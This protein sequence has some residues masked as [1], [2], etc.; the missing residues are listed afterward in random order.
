[1]AITTGPNPILDPNDPTKLYGSDM[2]TS[3]YIAMM[4]QWVNS[5]NQNSNRLPVDTTATISDWISSHTTEVL[6]GLVFLV[7]VVSMGGRR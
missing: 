6:I 3:D 1:M 4:E 7:G 2:N 5:G